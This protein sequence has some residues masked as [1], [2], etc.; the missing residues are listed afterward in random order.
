MVLIELYPSFAWNTMHSKQCTQKWSFLAEN[1]L[2]GL[3]ISLKQ[4]KQSYGQKRLSSPVKNA[5][6]SSQNFFEFIFE[7]ISSHFRLIETDYSLILRR[8][9]LK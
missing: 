1:C 2:L 9:N 5:I 4:P 3:K 8:N 6:I 7:S